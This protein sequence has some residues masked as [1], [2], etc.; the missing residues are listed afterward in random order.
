MGF[1]IYTVTYLHF[2]LSIVII[3]KLTQDQPHFHYVVNWLDCNI[4]INK[5]EVISTFISPT[6]YLSIKLLINSHPLLFFFFWE[7]NKFL[8]CMND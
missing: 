6:H 7:K 1:I 8:W 5:E 3:E 4:H 2:L